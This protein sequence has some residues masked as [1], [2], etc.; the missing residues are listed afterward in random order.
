MYKTIFPACTAFSAGGIGKK[1]LV[2][3]MAFDKTKIANAVETCLKESIKRKFTQSV[4]LSINFKDV[5]FKKAE[6]RINVEVILPYQVKDVKVGVFADKALEFEAK[7]VF[8]LVIT[9]EGLSAYS[10]KK[11]Q[12]ELLNYVLL[13]SPSLMAQVGKVL[14][15]VLGSKGRLPKPILPNSNLKELAERAK[16][17]ITLKCKGKFHPTLNCRVG[18]ET[19]EVEKITENILA[20]LEAIEKVIPS[21]KISSVFV[22]TTMGKAVKVF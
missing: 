13:S 7:K 12:K 17:T 3:L 10:D 21:Q 11:K 20:V 8:D 5:D 4:D 14:G 9:A 16:R 1:Y 18:V 6:Q 22:K 19:M 2:V 15:Q